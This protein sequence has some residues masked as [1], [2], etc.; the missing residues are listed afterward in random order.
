MPAKSTTE[1][2][3]H[4]FNVIVFLSSYT[5][6]VHF[7]KEGSE[8]RAWYNLCESW[9]RGR[10]LVIIVGKRRDLLFPYVADHLLVNLSTKKAVKNN[11]S[12]HV[13]MIHRCRRKSLLARTRS[14]A[15]LGQSMS[16]RNGL[17]FI[18]RT[19]T[20]RS[21]L[22]PICVVKTLTRFVRSCVIV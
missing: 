4:S 14:D 6:L 20:V 18:H 12:K 3:S 5:Q 15:I 10:N 8:R 21:T 13:T 22:K 2:T 17:S 11:S 19:K 7:G 9:H 1:V 16:L